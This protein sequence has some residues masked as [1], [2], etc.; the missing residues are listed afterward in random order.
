MTQADRLLPGLNVFT[1]R[2]RYYTFLCW[3]LDRAQAAESKRTHLERVLRLERLLVL[4]EAL[5]HED[6][7]KACS[8]IGRRRGRRFVSERRGAG[9][10]ELPTKILK[11]QASSGALR[12]YRTSLASLGLIEEDDFDDGLGLHLTVRGKQLAGRISRVDEGVVAW[13]LEG[14]ARTQKRR[15]TIEGSA[16]R[17][18][19]SHRPGVL[20]RRYLVDALLGNGGEQDALSRRDTV[21]ILFEH[22]LLKGGSTGDDATDNEPVTDGDEEAE[23]AGGALETHTNWKVLRPALERAPSNRLHPIQTTGAYQLVA[24]GLNALF[25]SALEPVETRGRISLSKWRKEI[26]THAGRDFNSV[27][28]VTWAARQDSPTDIAA[29]LL[30][31]VERPWAEVGVLATQLLLR[32]GLE[33]RYVEWLGLEAPALVERVLLWARDANRE[34]A[35][36]MIEKL[37]PELVEHHVEVSAKKGKGEWMVMEGDVV[38]RRSPRPLRLLLHSLRFAQLGQ[39]A[40]DLDLG[41]EDV[42]DEA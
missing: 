10:W 9:L 24:L 18:C 40:A 34:R 19:L 2:A 31:P 42:A 17:L 7:P 8:Y 33:D 16:E 25:A 20:E 12:L 3:A 32:L 36:D 14:G 21:Q 39:L 5:R 30:A 26:A 11:N 22:D 29:E 37:L 27:R 28:A 4:C 6:D 41:P 35:G 1:S 38:V 13:A 23:K 15:N